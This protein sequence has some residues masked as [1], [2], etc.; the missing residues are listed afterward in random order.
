M[1]K[2][3]MSLMLVCAL[4]TVSAQATTQ[5]GLKAAFDELNYALTVEWDQK[6]KDFYMEQMKSFRSKISDLQAMGLSNQELIEF[7]KSEVKNKKLAAELETA[8]TMIS[9]N[10]M[11]A[12]Q[13]SEYLVDIVKKGYST[14]A[15]WNSD[16]GIWIGVGVLLIVVG[17]AVAAGGGGGSSSGGGSYYCTDIYVCDWTCYNDY[18]YGYT[19][20]DYCYWTCY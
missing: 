12:E 11:N 3:M 16:A 13:A 8:F 10:K 20:Y 14:G 7:A 5:N 4:F 18:Y 9:I 15:S 2:R 1:F 6:D 17:I 19:C